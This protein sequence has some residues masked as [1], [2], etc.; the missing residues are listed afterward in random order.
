MELK[1]ARKNARYRQQDVADHLGVSRQTYSRMEQHPEAVSVGDARKLAE[2]FGVTVD[3]IFFE[4]D[5]K[6]TYSRA[7]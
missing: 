7:T 4:S 3:D 5:Y 2:F 1:E 6:E